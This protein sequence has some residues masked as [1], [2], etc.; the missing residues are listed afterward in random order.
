M[1]PGV[2]GLCVLVLE[3]G[4]VLQPDE[5]W[6]DPTDMLRYDATSKTMRQERKKAQDTGGEVTSCPV[7]KDLQAEDSAAERSCQNKLYILQRE[8]KNLKCRVDE[9]LEQE[10]F[11]LD[12]ESKVTQLLHSLQDD[13]SCTTSLE[14][15]T[16]NIKSRGCI[17]ILLLMVCTYIM[18]LSDLM[19]PSSSDVVPCLLCTVV[20]IM[21]TCILV[22]FLKKRKHH[23]VPRE[24]NNQGGDNIRNDDGQPDN[25]RD[26][27]VNHEHHHSMENPINMAVEVL[28]PEILQEQNAGAAEQVLEGMA[29]EC[30]DENYEIMKVPTTE[31]QPAR[32]YS[33]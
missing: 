21:L 26:E 7:N 16:A 11:T 24:N 22:K 23:E 13:D 2:W 28:N 27:E 15:L 1:A 10:G 20:T 5:E 6:I 14:W 19:L 4:T 30:C 31:T 8:I 33:S 25:E 9:L 32:L 29:D 12:P 18:E 3:V 17:S